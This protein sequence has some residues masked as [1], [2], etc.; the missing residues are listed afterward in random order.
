M[1]DSYSPVRPVVIL[2][3]GHAVPE[4]VVLSSQ[5]DAQLKHKPGTIYKVGGVYQRHF[6][7][8]EDNA[9]KLGAKAALLA[10]QAAQLTLDDMDC[11][12]AASATMDQ[13]MPCNAALI[14]HELNV[15]RAMP[16]FDINASCMGF[17]AALD[18]LSWPI[19]AGRYR[20]ILIVASDVASRGLNWD[21]LE[22]SA[23]FGD[24]AAAAVIA[25]AEPGQSGRILNSVMSTFADGA[26]LCEIP[27]GGSRFHPRHI[28]QPFDALTLFKM[29]GKGVFKMAA[30]HLQDFVKQLLEGAGL[31]Q[32]D[33][34]WV[35]PHQASQ[36]GMNHAIKKLNLRRE[37]VID[38][39]ANYGNQVA[40]SLP[41][42]LDIAVRDGRIQR[43]Q[44]LMMV[45]TG[46]GLS[47]G[48]VVLEY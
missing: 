13:G 46:A 4:R 34:A 28:S 7:T 19:A 38:I 10:L 20:R 18:T 29:D 11:I 25:R 35:V 8:P 48:G 33:I 22:S 6:V 2:G 41:T 3:T 9:A 23:I 39:F 1:N 37:Q 17:L 12:I 32:S 5:L 21:H 30:L 40:A 36:L 26:H 42:A 24:G 31:V 15:H 45:G 27:A 14:A 16:A 44:R 47:M 43:G